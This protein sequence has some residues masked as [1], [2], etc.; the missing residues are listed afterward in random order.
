[1]LHHAD[2][3]VLP[4]GFKEQMENLLKDENEYTQFI[5]SYNENPNY[6]L[7]T[8][9]LKVTPD[10][11]SSMLNLGEKVSWCESGFYFTEDDRPSKSPFYAAGLYYIQEP[12]AMLPAV[13]LDVRQNQKVL[14]LCGA[15]GGKTTFLAERL[16][17]TGLLVANDISA[18]R[19]QALRQN[20]ELFGVKNAVVTAENPDKLAKVFPSFFDRVLVDAPCSGEGMFRKSPELIKQWEKG[21]EFCETQ[22]QILESAAKMVADGGKIVYSTCTFNKEENEDIIYKFLEKHNEFRLVPI[23]HEK[24]GVSK[25]LGLSECARIFPHQQKGEGH[26]AAC[27]EKRW[28]ISVF[29][30]R[31]AKVSENELFTDFCNK[32][33]SEGFLSSLKGRFVLH[34]NSLF[35]QPHTFPENTKLR[36]IRSGLHLG[37]IK[38]GRFAPAWHLAMALKQGE[39]QNSVSYPIDDSK[40]SAYLRGDS[41]DV[42]CADGYALFCVESLRNQGFPL[43]FGK[44]VNG[45]MKNLYRR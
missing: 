36:V 6:G 42:P 18:T 10:K 3:H 39:A 38:N 19:C 15:P 27:L 12:S 44:V 17:E 23:E 40:V 20:L 35:L 21:R 4:D 25:G 8:N 24:L 37:E 2:T 26:F 1:M 28:D 33:L 45:R 14:D 16:N 5:E 7:R 34:N 11:L 31:E 41:F 32:H 29:V 13:L 30:E 9:T 43:G 22:S